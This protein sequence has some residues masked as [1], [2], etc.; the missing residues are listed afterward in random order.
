VT[1]AEHVAVWPVEFVTVPTKVVAVVIAGVVVAPDVVATA[2][3]SWSIRKDM[4][5]TEDHESV[6]LAPEFMTVGSAESVQAGAPGGGGDA[7]VIVAEQ[8]ATPPFPVAV[9]V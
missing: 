5:F 3:T 4:A 6:T 8:C 2:P 7:M 9:P 1:A